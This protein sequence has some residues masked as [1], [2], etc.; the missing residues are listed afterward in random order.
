[1]QTVNHTANIR[2]AIQE[3]LREQQVRQRCYPKWVKEGKQ[4]N[5]YEATERLERLAMA[6]EYLQNLEPAVLAAQG[7]RIEIL[8]DAA[9]G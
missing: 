8:P 3:L 4:L 1:M 5:A 6:I 9:A 7:P 2:A